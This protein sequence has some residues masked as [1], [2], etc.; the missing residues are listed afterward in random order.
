VFGSDREPG[1]ARH[2][3]S[4]WG[5]AGCLRLGFAVTLF[6][7]ALDGWGAGPGWALDPAAVAGLV[8]A[9]VVAASAV[10]QVG[11]KLRESKTF[12]VAGMLLDTGVAL[13]M[14]ALFADDPRPYLV[15]L[16]FLAE[17]EAGAI[18][19]L[20]DGVLVWGAASALLV[21]IER[22][23]TSA[24]T[25]LNPL[26]LA[27]R[28]GVGLL[29]TLGAGLLSGELSRER[30]RGLEQR[31]EELRRLQSLMG[32]LEAIV[33][34]AD[35][36]TGRFTFVSRAAEAVLGFPT[37]QWLRE[38]GFWEHHILPADHARTV[39]RR[40][41]VAEHGGSDELEYR[42][43]AADGR[44]VWFR[45]IVQAVPGGP[46]PAGHP[47]SDG[48]SRPARL[49]GLM[50]DVTE[51]R[52]AEERQV[53][54]TNYLAALHETAL[55]AIRRLDPS[56][57]LQAI[58]ARAASLVGTAQGYAYLRDG[59]EH[60]VVKV[61]VGLFEEFVGMRMA[62]GEGMAGRV[63]ESGRP[64]VI[65]DYDTWDGRSS[66]FPT[67]RVHAV[68]GVPLISGGRVTGAI[69]LA[70]VEPHRHFSQED[71]ALLSKFAEIASLCLDNAELYAS[72]QQELR[73]RRRAE[74]ELSFIAFHDT[75][76]GLP[77][78]A[79]FEQSLSAA[80]GRARQRDQAVAVL[81]LDIDDFKL[82]NDSLGH[83]AGDALLRE[84]ASRVRDA[85]RTGDIVARQGGDE[86]LILLSDLE[87]MTEDGE[88]PRSVQTA[89]AA[90]RRIQAELRK[91]FLLSGT[92]LY[93]SVSMGISVFPFTASDGPSLLRFAD[94]AMYASKRAG[95]GGCR[96]S[97][98][99]P[100][101]SMNRLSVT[102]EL[103]RA[104]EKREWVLHYQPIVDLATGAV[105][106]VEALL[107]WRRPDGSLVV[108][109][110]FI[111]E[112]E[113][114]GLI[115]AVGEWVLDEVCR[116]S[117]V[118]RSQRNPM[119]VSFNLS[120][121]QLWQPDVASKIVRATER[122]G[123]TPADIVIEITETSALTDP[124]R[125]WRIFRNLRDQGFRLAIDDF[126]TGYSSLSRLKQLPADIL[127]IDRPFL[128]GVPE[129]P[130]AANLI[131]AVLDVAQT[132]GMQALV[133][134]IETEEQRRFLVKHGCLL[135][136]GY[137]FGRPI[138][139]ELVAGPGLDF[140]VVRIG[141]A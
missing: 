120:L 128:R 31:S 22:T 9:T 10:L 29:V 14:L 94:S 112:I 37:E 17:G 7:Y 89:E 86:F 74:E 47:G 133:E 70:Q 137:Y 83:A 77:N 100:D 4:G 20:R 111:D 32:G 82:V 124:N 113:E 38:P 3:M 75:L 34:E 98:G 13:T 68:V 108:A 21:I 62:S 140:H 65:E 134:G 107:R 136:Q 56:E 81:Y 41:A 55:A 25:M 49:R 139:P 96:L 123:V 138:A 42:F 27:L 127:K 85:A 5:W 18:L 30:L 103:I 116:Q 90:A 72:A 54:Q 129:D 35:A 101:D 60:L 130:N 59:D 93:V 61:G 36:R 40:R 102:T 45:D 43:I 88:T 50:F 110:D 114:M 115:G 57:L 125:T 97:V 63:I 6:V 91:P 53:R 104:V 26:D 121:A 84:T 131:R 11:T 106:G 33:W 39:S 79:M 99:E 87:G 73:Q 52:R 117:G 23:A 109:G 58:V 2:L 64:M 44:T 141:A 132:L 16:L 66:Q 122:A 92:E 126:G 71:V 28:V 76:T 46:V 1:F 135:G 119:F 80:I 15:V 69:G 48:R 19:G 78:R 67:G 105:E 12:A 118:W 24:A 8:L 95:R 51:R